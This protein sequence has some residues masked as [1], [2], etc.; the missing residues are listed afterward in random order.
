[1]DSRKHQPERGATPLAPLLVLTFL[2]SAATAVMWNGL[3]FVAKEGYAFPEWKTSLLFALNGCIYA[4]TAF[5]TGPVLRRLGGRVTP[6]ATLLAVLLIQ[7]ASAPLVAFFDGSW[8]IW[9]VSL[10]FSVTSALLWS[11]V[12]SFMSAGRHGR[13]M[14]TTIGWWNL[15]WMTSNALA[16][17]AMAPFM[18]SAEHSRWAVAVLGPLCLVGALMLLRFPA[19]PAPHVEETGE[20]GPPTGAGYGPLL[21]TSRIMLPMSYVLIGALGP[22]MPY[23]LAELEIPLTWVTPLTATWLIARVGCVLLMSRLHFWHGRWGALATAGGVMLLGFGLITLAPTILAVT[24]G[25][26]LVGIGQGLTYYAAIYYAL[27]VGRAEIDAAGTHE[28]LIGVGY[29]AGPAAALVGLQL[30]GG[31][32]VAWVV[33]VLVVLTAGP[34]VTPWLRARRAKGA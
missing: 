7:T 30:G 20:T 27:S 5:G 2:A 17:A 18:S 33:M 22:I 14:R 4:A 1:M 6:R 16:L 25:L 23:R 31:T 24:A 28:G 9:V 29:A 12:E 10:L 34:A 11:L 26:A 3:G 13:S 32:S 19:A 8:A 15:T 21:R